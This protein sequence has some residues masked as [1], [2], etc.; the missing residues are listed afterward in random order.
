MLSGF[1]RSVKVSSRLCRNSA[2]VCF[3]FL[4]MVTFS[5]FWKGCK[6][7]QWRYLKSGGF[8]N[9]HHPILKFFVCIRKKYC[10]AHFLR[11]KR[12]SPVLVNKYLRAIRRFWSVSS[13]SF[14]AVF[15]IGSSARMF[16]R[17]SWR[18]IT[19]SRYPHLGLGFFKLPLALHESLSNSSFLVGDAECSSLQALPELMLSRVI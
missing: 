13:V 5:R 15:L 18:L 16:I 17:P 12:V 4:I 19:Q 11:C 14:W 7:F 2:R 9:P 6:W 10:S 8:I 3:R 1:L